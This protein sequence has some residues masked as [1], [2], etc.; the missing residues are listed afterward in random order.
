MMRRLDNDSN[1]LRPED[2]I[3]RIGDLSCHLFLNLQPLGIDPN[4]PCELADANH[5]AA[6]NVAYPGLTDDGRHM[7]LAVALE[8]NATQHNHL[9]IA[10]DFLE[11]LFQDFDRIL[12]IA[13]E[14]L[15][16]RARHTSGR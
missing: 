4:H 7:M 16:K 10:F 14:K 11:S 15:L 12:S 8:A 2:V 6:W 9:V 3:D 13:D 5:A 1:T